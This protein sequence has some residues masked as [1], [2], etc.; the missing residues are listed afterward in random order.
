MFSS[1]NVG[2]KL[3]DVPFP[4]MIYNMASAIAKSQLRLDMASIEILRQMGDKVNYPVYLP[5]IRL[6]SSG[7]LVD[8]EDDNMVTSMIGAG[9]QPTFYQF[10]ETMIE[11]QMAVS[12]VNEGEEPI[13][14]QSNL[15]E[16]QTTTTF[17]SAALWNRF[18]ILRPL[19]VR[20]S[21]QISTRVTPIDASYTNKY[22]FAQEGSSTIKTRLMPMPPNPFIQRL[23]DMK[24]Q[25]MQQQ[26]ELELRNIELALAKEQREVME[27]LAAADLEAATAAA[28]ELS[29]TP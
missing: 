6:D 15:T 8:G 11:V 7:D 9:F 18:P 25:A 20:R 10:V 21:T 28:A 5:K 3:L 22:S 12:F 27:A 13:I 16:T 29:E 23:L 19:A 2:Q 24:A 26:F 14:Q 1:I 4:E 17:T